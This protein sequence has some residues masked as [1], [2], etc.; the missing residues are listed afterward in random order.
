MDAVL[1]MNFFVFKPNCW[2]RATILHRFLAQRGLDTT[3]AFGL[4]KELNGELK[5][6]AWLEFEGRP[7]LETVPP[8]YTVTYTFPSTDRFDGELALMATSRTK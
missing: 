4:R 8:A 1:G 5:G 6:H 3:I 7:I 2:K